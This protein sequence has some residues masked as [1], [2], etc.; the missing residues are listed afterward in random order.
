MEEQ[1]KEQITN[2]V[3]NKDVY[4]HYFASILI[5]GIILLFIIFCPVLNESI[6]NEVLNYTTFFILYYIA[7][8]VFALP[9]YLWLKPES[10]LTSRNV[11]ICN[12]FKRQ[13]RK[14]MTLQ[15]WLT[16]IEPKK[17][18]KQA[19]MILF[20]KTFFGVYCVNIL[21]N[22]Y[23]PALDYDIAFLKEMLRLA[24][25]YSAASGFLA[26]LWQFIDDTS[27]MWVTIMLMIT[28]IIFAFSYLTELD[29]F[30]NKIKS[31]DTTPLGV[32]TCIICYYPVIILTNQIIPKYNDELIPVD[33]F[34]LR[35]LLNILVVVV[36]FGALL[37]IARLGTKAG[38][39]TNRGI[40]TRFPYSIIRH[41]NYSMQICYIILTSLPILLLSGYSILWKAIMLVGILSWIGIYYLRAI[42]EERHLIKDIAYREYAKRVK[43]RFIP[44]VF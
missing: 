23:L 29:L 12:Y 34:G 21:C 33:N 20:M 26:A 6:E 32:I 2:K 5:Y 42:T 13:F 36:N 8:A 3:T 17:V 43:Y 31:I 7:Y 14:D 19:F 15:Q 27:D 11:A 30:K 16:H 10:I 25:N 28:N 4:K 24:I 41:P 37:A 39:L 35:I 22:K 40:E 18:E 38:N 44:K 9:L 1:E